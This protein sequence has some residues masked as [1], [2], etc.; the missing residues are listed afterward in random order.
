MRTVTITPSNASIT[1]V[2]VTR[3]PTAQTSFLDSDGNSQTTEQNGDAQISP[4]RG[5]TTITSSAVST[6]QIDFSGLGR[7]DS[8]A[9]TGSWTIKVSYLVEAFGQYSIEIGGTVD[10]D[11]SGSP[12]TAYV[13]RSD[14]LARNTSIAEGSTRTPVLGTSSVSVTV[15]PSNAW[16]RVDLRV[17]GGKLYLD[18][19]QYLSGNKLFD[20]TQ[21]KE[22]TSLSMFT[23]DDSSTTNG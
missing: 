3:A 21:R 18:S 15:S 13:V 9:A 20:V 5:D 7:P 23:D 22:F 19:G 17:T 16:T 6:S 11:V 14:T 8:D 12:I 1:E 4:A 10:T 2:E